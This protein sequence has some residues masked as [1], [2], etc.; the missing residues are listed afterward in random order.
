MSVKSEP[1]YWL[2][3]DGVNKDGTPCGRKSTENGDFSAWSDMDG[4]EAEADCSDWDIT[5][6]PGK[7]YCP[8]H[9]PEEVGA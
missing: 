9:I 8:F 5:S 2:E 3:C 6:T 4:A 1:Y 7:H